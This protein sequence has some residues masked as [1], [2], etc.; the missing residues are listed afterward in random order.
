MP[1]LTVGAFVYFCASIVCPSRNFENSQRLLNSIELRTKDIAGSSKQQ[2]KRG[3]KSRENPVPICI[4]QGAS[5]EGLL[6]GCYWAV[7]GREVRKKSGRSG[8]EWVNLFSVATIVLCGAVQSF[9]ANT[10]WVVTGADA[11]WL[12]KHINQQTC[13]GC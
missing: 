6:A 4:S 3:Y 5:M 13:F 10:G 11:V 7:W 8:A 9:L 1:L 2:Q 12:S